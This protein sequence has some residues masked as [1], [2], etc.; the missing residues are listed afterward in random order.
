MKTAGAGVPPV[1]GYK[2]AR[3]LRFD[4]TQQR[5]RRR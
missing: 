2:L 1:I 3:L 5:R 4:V